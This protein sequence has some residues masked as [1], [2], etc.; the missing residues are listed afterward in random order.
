MNKS[1]NQKSIHQSIKQATNN[2]IKKRSIN[3]SITNNR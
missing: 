1:I 2:G 3:Q